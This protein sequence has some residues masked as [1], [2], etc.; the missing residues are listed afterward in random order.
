MCISHRNALAFVEWSAT[1]LGL[2]DG[3]RLANHAPFNFDLSVFDLYAAFF[4]GAS[5]HLIP[6]AASYAPRQLVEFMQRRAIT[7]WY[8]VP[9]V[10]VLMMSQG[11]LLRAAM[12]ALHTIVFA[13]EVFPITSLKRLQRGLGATRLYNF[14][15][16]T[17]TNVCTA[18]EVPALDADEQRE[19]PIGRAASGDTVYAVRADGERAQPGEQGELWVEGPTVMLGYWGKPRQGAAPYRTGDQRLGRGRRRLSL[20]R[21]HRQSGQGARASHRARRNRDCAES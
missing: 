8:S 5:V 1:E 19:V 21:A 7:V 17:E 3:D 12:P 20:R 11:G 10:L 4:A 14:Y 13:G 18:Y 6:E 2:D 9:S 15:G 16:P